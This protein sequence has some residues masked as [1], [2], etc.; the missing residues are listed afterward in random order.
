MM[1]VELF[2]QVFLDSA[3]LS[4]CVF[5][6][7]GWQGRL[8]NCV[9]AGN[10]VI[11]LLSRLTG[12][13]TDPVAYV[14]VPLD[15]FVFVLFLLLA[16]LLLN[17]VCFD[18]GEAHIFWGTTMQFALFLLLREVCFVVLGLLDLSVGFWPVY[19]VRMLSLLLWAALWGTGLLRWIREQLKEGDTPL[20]IIIGNSF[21]ILLLAW[22][23]WQADLLR[24]NLWL[25][26]M[27]TLLALLVLIDGMVLLWD[28]SR[29]QFQRRGRLL[30]QYLPMVEE[31]V[32]SVRAQQ[33]EYNNRMMAISAAVMTTGT[34]DEA[35]AK[36]TELT[37]QISLSPS[38]RELLKCDSKLLCGMLFGKIM[39]AQMQ[40]IQLRISIGGSF[41]HRSLSESDWID[42]LG[43]LLDNALEASSGGD[44]VYLQAE[45][46][47]NALLLLVSNPC[48]PISRT[49]MTEMFRRGWST[50]A[51]Q[52]RGYG[53]YNVRK[54]VEQHGGKII[55]K[56]E[57]KNGQNYLT[58][59]AL[60]S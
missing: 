32:E 17:S 42:L 22:R 57:E 34:L 1:G 12:Y 33:H 21:L 55:V 13:S 39:Q 37:G 53:L 8:R 15:N 29:I 52:G 9:L 14:V 6:T 41:L 46:E 31:L 36:I 20:C 10:F 4:A 2:V 27:A 11:C 24:T 49:E 47:V 30:E 3:L 35:K 26:I 56:N 60:I 54:M 5:G 44:T 7:L 19:G 58:I 25:P 48:P 59:G 50:K 43:I 16:V 28:Q 45:D 51:D 23:V 18:S 38:D 40:H